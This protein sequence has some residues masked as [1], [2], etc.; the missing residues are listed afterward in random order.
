MGAS[1]SY[2]FEVEAAADG[3]A[4]DVIVREGDGP[5]I[6]PGFSWSWPESS[7]RGLLFP[8]KLLAP[9]LRAFRGSH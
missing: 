7:A 6:T 5:A 1:P 3:E 2:Q 4:T 8:P 9:L